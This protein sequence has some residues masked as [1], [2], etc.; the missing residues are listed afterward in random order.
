VY[1]LDGM[2]F[3]TGVSLDGVIEIGRWLGEQLRKELPS[4]LDRA[5]GFPAA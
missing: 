5:G 4:M 3:E 2:G 1:L